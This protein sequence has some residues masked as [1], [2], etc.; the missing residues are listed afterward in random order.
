MKPKLRF[1]NFNNEW[2]EVELKNITSE[3]SYGMNSASKEYDG[4][5]KYIRI[6]DIDENSN[7]YSY[8]DV[9]SPDGILEDKFL[10]KDNDILFAR[11][12]AST[13]KTYL[14]NSNDGKLYYAGF[15][16][17]ASI[18]NH[19]SNFI[20]QQT[21]LNKYNN[22]IKIMSMRS[23]QPGI[24][25]QEYGSYKFSVTSIDEENKVSNFLSLLDKKI[26]LQSKKIEDLKLFKL[27]YYNIIFSS[28]LYD[29]FK[30]GDVVSCLDKKRKPISSELRKQGIYP[31]YGANG[32]QDYIDD[33]IFDGCYVLLAEDGGNFSD[34]NTKSIAQLAKGKIWVNNHAHVLV[35][36]KIDTEFLFYQLEH[37]D[38][39]QYINGTSRSKLNQEDMMNILLQIPSIEEQKKISKVFNT[40]EKKIYLEKIKYEKLTELKKGLMQSMFV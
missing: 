4:E 34:Y 27:Y 20:F 35:G 10:V 30:L 12:G 11:T 32:I 28:K 17:K 33:Y 6:T 9:V 7:R 26:E 22:W 2:E 24:N 31:Y 21:K 36:D 13:G 29:C 19:N 40:I 16:I 3:I 37:M 8:K 5:N 14:Y 38:I 15:L 18:I 23:G 1:N 39:R 25:S